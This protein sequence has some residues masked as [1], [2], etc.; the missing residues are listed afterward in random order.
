F[1]HFANKTTIRLRINFSVFSYWQRGCDVIA[2][3]STLWNSAH[4]NSSAW[5][6][7]ASKSYRYFPNWSPILWIL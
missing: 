4:H 1:E 5:K 7:Y 6:I 3:H 2:R